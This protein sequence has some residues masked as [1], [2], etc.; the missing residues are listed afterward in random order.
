[1]KRSLFIIAALVLCAISGKAQLSE[2]LVES[3]EDVGENTN[4]EYDRTRKPMAAIEV[5]TNQPMQG[6]VIIDNG[7]AGPKTDA[8]NTDTTFY[9]HAVASDIM[10]AKTITLLHPDFQPLNIDLSKYPDVYPPKGERSYRIS[11]S[12]PS[13]QLVLA[14]KAFD[15]LKYDEAEELYRGITTPENEYNIAQMR[16]ATIA[17]LKTK[18]SEARKYEILSDKNGKV[19]AMF[20]YKDIHRLTKSTVAKARKAK[21]ERSLFHNKERSEND[22]IGVSLLTVASCKETNGVEAKTNTKIERI[23]PAQP[24]YALIIVSV[25][26]DSVTFSCENVL[27]NVFTEK[28]EY[29]VTMEP[30]EKGV[31]T[32]FVIKHRD[33]RPLLVNLKD[34]NIDKLKSGITYRMSIAAPSFDMMEADRNYAVLEFDNALPL[35]SRIDSLASEYPEADVALARKRKQICIAYDQERDTWEDLRNEINTGGKLIDR[36]DICKKIDKLVELSNLF[37]DLDIPSAS[38]TIE[39]VNK[40][41]VKY[42]KCY[43]LSL[44]V[45]GEKGAM[46]SPKLYV[47]F[48]HDKYKKVEV[49]RKLPGKND[50]YR[51]FLPEDLSEYVANGGTVKFTV[52]EKI[53]DKGGIDGHKSWEK[54]IVK[55]GK[56]LNVT[57]NMVINNSN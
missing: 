25:P 16:L 32:P 43:H 5:V 3:I 4:P 23:D 56:N 12:I 1:M 37:V 28:G 55:D 31:N 34:Y 52:A 18:L 45:T 14:N 50:E 29:Y 11:V 22:T 54:E 2:M 39:S 40:L 30:G 46:K 26:L 8:V 20:I 41:R 57:Y 48:K 17:D 47:E 42:E 44:H 53:N 33:C 27:H 21:L 35:Y 36:D 9:G 19:R 10:W 24:Y 38:A 7:Q 13:A 15:Q 51:L 6:L 49:A